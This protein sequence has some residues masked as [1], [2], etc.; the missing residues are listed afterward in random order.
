MAQAKKKTKKK[1]RFLMFVISFIALLMFCVVGG[2][3]ALLYA[4]GQM[5]DMTKLEDIKLEPTE[6]YDKFGTKV[7]NLSSKENNRTYVKYTDIPKHVIDAFICVEDKRFFEHNGVDM[8]RVAGAIFKDLTKG[9]LAEGGS[10]I[11]QQ[12]ARNVFLSNDKTFWRKTKE[13]S[14]A[15]NLEQHFSKEEIMEMYLN[16]VYLGHG[17]YG[18]GNAAQLYYGKNV[19]DLTLDEAAM[20]ASIPKGPSIY[21]PFN[22]PDKAKERRDTILRLMMEQGV[23]TKA[24]K[25]Q[26]QQQPLPSKKV[27]LP[28][29]INPSYASYV[30]YVVQEAEEKYS[31]SEDML[32]RGGW[33]IYTSLDPKMQDSMANAFAKDS[34]F[35]KDGP[36]QKVEAGM[37]VV[38]PKTGGVAAM[39][40][41]RGY[42]HK[43]FSH[44]TDMRRQPGS[45]FKPLAVYAP[46]FDTGNWNAGSSLPNNKQDFGGY[47]PSNWNGKYSDSV[48]LQYAVE[49][50][51]NIPAVW[52]LN[53]IGIGKSLDYL[54]K[55]GIPLEPD[56]RNLAIALGGLSKGVSPLIMAQAYTAFDNGGVMS[57]AHAITS[58]KDEND[59][60]VAT[61]K[62]NQTQVIS[63]DTAW[64]VHELLRAVVTNGT[65]KAANMDRPVAGKTGTTQSPFGGSN[66]NKDAWFVG[67]TPEYVGAV[68]MG[69]D[70]E[71]RDHLMR[72]GSSKTAKLFKEVFRDGL[73]G[74]DITPF[75]PPGG[76]RDTQPVETAKPITLEATLAMENNEP[77]VVLS[78]SGS[79]A[80]DLTYDVYRF[81]DSPD[82]KELLVAGLKDTKF[83]DPVKGAKIYQYLIVAHK[84]DG[85]DGPS[86]NVAK[87]DMSQIDQMLKDDANQQQQENNTPTDQQGNNNPENKPAD[88]PNTD[89]GGTNTDNNNSSGKPN[90]S[91]NQGPSDNNNQGNT[92][93]T[94]DPNSPPSGNQTP[95]QP[96]NGQGNGH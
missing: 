44:A 13:M 39:M 18:I 59:N 94:V 80:K 22:N 89:N 37:V 5:V 67:Y 81:L 26:A 85:T 38:D 8:V 42:T 1:N 23:I 64:R 6:L 25:E 73:N 58:I 62:V 46:A 53:E 88:I 90:G 56:D 12:L 24:E 65:G 15:I 10:T 31:I 36:K 47:K 43:G 32:Y 91:D 55:F 16:K 27:V 19:K 75:T 84:A 78:W 28:G 72:D 82:N 51:L 69:F 34:L 30:D 3:F 92:N 49:Q 20:L 74:T 63:P 29:T 57:E 9:E 70:K 21:S 14:I 54:K 83:V 71:D 50:S 45:S 61:A 40:G 48:N 33:K 68:W 87:V 52:L 86:S 96:T 17:V 60:V 4:G 95:D 76:I 7:G 35:P 2:Y 79:D 66:V 41:G 11:T 93:G 77:K